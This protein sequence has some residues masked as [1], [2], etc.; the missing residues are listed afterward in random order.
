MDETYNSISAHG[1]HAF[2]TAA[3]ANQGPLSNA[4]TGNGVGT[5]PPVNE[6]FDR[7]VL[8][9]G[10]KTTV[11]ISEPSSGPGGDCSECNTSEPANAVFQGASEDG[12]KV[13]FLSRQHLLEGPEG[14]TLYEYNS[15]ADMGRRI[16]LV[17]S[18]AMGVA[19]VSEDGSHIYFVAHNVLTGANREGKTP[20]TGVPNLYVSEMACP[21]GGISCATPTYRTLFIGALAAEDEEI[22]Q[23]MDLRP[24][25]ATPDGRFLVFTSKADMTADDTSNVGQVFEYDSATEVLKRVSVGQGGFNNDGNT[26]EF[27]ASIVSPAYIGHQ[28]PAPQGKAVSDDG[29]FVVFQSDNALTPQAAS[30]VANVYEYHLGRVSLISDGQDR[31]L[32]PGGIPSTSL[33]G[34]D[35]SGSDIF[36]TTVVPLVTQDGDTQQD[37]YDAR[38]DGGFPAPAA[39]PACEGDGC[40]GSLAL[41]PS[42]TSVS[43]LIQSGG[44]QVS[45]TPPTE[46]AKKA[47]EKKPKKSRRP[48]RASR[49]HGKTKKRHSARTSLK[50]RR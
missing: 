18:G 36:F 48:K 29:A 28:N 50:E 20:V 14:L 46:K 38:V 42:F 39:P 17:A 12:S 24:V 43:S 2:F 15:D 1:A 49:H 8:P 40:Q 32:G 16:T 11:A 45:E 34:I 26:D 35:G 25:N 31:T 3:A 37:L 9:S 5:G 4:C 33:V 23:Q 6:L 22:W 27:P 10:E 41:A 13:L 7:E 19:R 21:D 47:V 44:E 30:G